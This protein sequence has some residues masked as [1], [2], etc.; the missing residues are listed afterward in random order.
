MSGD[1][2]HLTRK[3]EKTEE[4]SGSGPFPDST[5]KTKDEIQVDKITKT[6]EDDITKIPNNEDSDN[7]SKLPSK[8]SGD[9]ERSIQSFFDLLGG[10]TI[11]LHRDA[12]I[13]PG[14]CDFD[15]KKMRPAELLM[16]VCTHI[17]KCTRFFA[18][19]DDRIPYIEV[20]WKDRIEFTSLP[21]FLTS[22][23][24]CLYSVF[25]K[26]LT[27][28]EL[29]PTIG[30]NER[31]TPNPDYL[32]FPLDEFETKR[33]PN[34]DGA[35]FIWNIVTLIDTPIPFIYL[36][37]ILE[38]ANVSHV[39]NSIIAYSRTRMPIFRNNFLRLLNYTSYYEF[40]D[41]TLPEPM[42]SVL[43]HP[44]YDFTL[45]TM[46]FDRIYHRNIL[47]YSLVTQLIMPTCSVEPISD[48][49][50]VS[51]A[52]VSF[53]R[54]TVVS[55]LNQ[56]QYSDSMKDDFS[57]I[58]SSLMCPGMVR[59]NIDFSDVEPADTDIRGVISLFCKAIFSF[60]THDYHCV[61]TRQCVEKLE[62]AILAYG[63]A[64]K[65]LDVDLDLRPDRLPLANAVVCPRSTFR[66]ADLVSLRT[67]D[68]GGG[69]LHGGPARVV[70]DPINDI[71]YISI[72]CC[73]GLHISVVD[74]SV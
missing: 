51:L 41:K 10:M 13:V 42:Y 40:S 24:D 67:D 17:D 74:L 7:K 65:V 18:V 69:W 56:I 36:V 25:V 32:G 20:K 43:F 31:R 64:R 44:V 22:Y 37:N 46:V 9:K 12:T 26:G 62:N 70:P 47:S 21:E 49:T 72:S 4:A 3:I 71:Y 50:I 14:M 27:I 59:F 5:P 8:S 19:G 34:F 68:M 45:S 6:S 11:V 23:V 16:S 55:T 58:V 1:S 28:V 15:L 2:A 73:S 60:S 66:P 63:V 54:S 38:P 48:K 52:G 35:D 53:N 61:L 29:P 33:I 57:L 39:R 30:R